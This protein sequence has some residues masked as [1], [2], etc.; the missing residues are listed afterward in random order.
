MENQILDNLNSEQKEVNYQK[1]AISWFVTGIISNILLKIVTKDI[2]E[3][4]LQLSNLND[5]VVI[6]FI[7]H[8][9]AIFGGLLVSF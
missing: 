3:K 6:F 1:R 7:K 4:L 8:E 5:L 2:D 9:A